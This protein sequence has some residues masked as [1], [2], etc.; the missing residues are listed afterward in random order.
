MSKNREYEYDDI[1][2]CI[3][4]PYEGECMVIW[5]VCKSV[6]VAGG[7]NE[8][9]NGGLEVHISEGRIDALNWK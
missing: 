3:S 9:I 1:I 4:R 2:M 7:R 8:E 5:R 6:C